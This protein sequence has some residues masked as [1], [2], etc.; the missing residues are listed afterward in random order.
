[1][2]RVRTAYKYPWERWLKPRQRALILRRG[3]DYLCT[4]HSMAIQVRNAAARLGVEIHAHVEEGKI[5]VRRV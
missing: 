1:M 4:T 2:T 5:T 3:K